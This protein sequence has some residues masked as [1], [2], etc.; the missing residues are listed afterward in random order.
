VVQTSG[1]AR[2]PLSPATL[3]RMTDVMEHRGPND[4]GTLI[5]PG[6]ALGARRLSI[7][8]VAG[9]HQPLAN[10][11]RT[12]WAVQNGELYNHT[13]LRRRLAAD[14]HT[15]RSRCD[16]EILP[17]LYE[18]YGV[19]FAEHLR[20][21]FAV[22]IWDSVHRRAVL[23]RDRLG[24]KPL[25]WAPAGD[26]VVFGSE[27]KS[28]VASG[29]VDGD[30]DHEAIDAYLTFG[31]IPGPRTPLAGVS[32]LGPG[33]RLVIDA[34]GVRVET[35][36][37]FPA[38]T[39]KPQPRL[40]D[41]EYEE[42][43][44]AAVDDAVRVRLM[45][46]VPLGA[47]L[48]GGLDS[49]FVVALMAKHMTSPV[50]TFSIGFAEAGSSNE[51]ADARLVSQALGTEHHELE[52]SFDEAAID[53]EDLVWHLDEPVAD[54]S[55]LGFMALSELAARSVT[56]ALSGQG[57]DELLGGYERYRTAALVDRWQRAP[58]VLRRPVEA[59]ARRGPAGVRR[60][61]AILSS[62]DARAHAVA[63]SE[64]SVLRR[65]LAKA[66][67]AGINGSVVEGIV[68]E[69]LAGFDGPGLAAA[70][71]LDSQLSLVDD[72]IHYFDRTSMA[73][74]LE[75]RVPFLDHHVVELCAALPLD[76]KVR[77]RQTK[78]VLKRIARGLVPDAI[79]DKRKLGFFSPAVNGWLTKQ[80]TGSAGDYLLGA[81]PRYGELLDQNSVRKLVSAHLEGKDTSNGRFVLSVLMLEVWL[82]SFLPR[83]RA[84]EARRAEEIAV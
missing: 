33:E 78:Y 25:Y 64:W 16:T 40:S 79:I 48:S 82:S 6:C 43:L 19:A 1:E 31:F 4:R 69:R 41:A 65:E 60:A 54:L 52:L 74:S 47:M 62:Q 63:R 66:P 80:L 58:H 75:V 42:R 56:V 17:H 29:L 50:K 70:M 35:Y 34:D 37:R 8:D 72:M 14:G 67:L 61:V 77:G 36:W 3:D 76:L 13:E 9:G 23:A 7:V 32:K 81:N 28:V 83:A 22:A 18:R 59:V 15:F 71:Y 30:L 12:I 39:V 46:D 55:S 2:P 73:R 57:A 45:S 68:N 51:L 10:E 84:S 24:I 20:G 5:H 27:L 11:D 26:L 38:P 49:S 44:L 53:L 21:K